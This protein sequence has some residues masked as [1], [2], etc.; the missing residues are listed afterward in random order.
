MHNHPGGPISDDTTEEEFQEV[1]IPYI[2]VLFSIVFFTVLKV[3]FFPRVLKGKGIILFYHLAATC[4]TTIQYIVL[5][6][7]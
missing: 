3:L 7:L 6:I 4:S 1:L 2:P 5:Y